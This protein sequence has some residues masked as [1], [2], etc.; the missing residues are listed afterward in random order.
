[1]IV[2]EHPPYLDNEDGTS[3]VRLDAA[4]SAQAAAAYV[5]AL[6]FDYPDGVEVK[7]IVWMRPHAHDKQCMGD[8]RD[9]FPV[10]EKCGACGA[11]VGRR[12]GSDY[13]HCDNGHTIYRGNEKDPPIIGCSKSDDGWYDEVAT[14]QEGVVSYWKVVADGT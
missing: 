9:V 1:V 4:P 11:P 12:N 14:P 3:Y 13:W 8:T 10:M 5:E 7:G 6:G 2:T